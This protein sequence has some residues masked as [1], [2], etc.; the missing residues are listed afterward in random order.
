MVRAQAIEQMQRFAR[1]V[2]P[3]LQSSAAQESHP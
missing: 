1:D 3:R 2:Q